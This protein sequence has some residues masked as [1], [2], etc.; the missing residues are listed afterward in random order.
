MSK[1][2]ERLLSEL[3]IHCIATPNPYSELSPNSYFVDGDSPTLI[4]TGLATRK[5]YEALASALSQLGRQISDIERIIL[6]HGHTDHRA[7][8]PRIGEESGAEVFFHSLEAGKAL[9]GWERDE[10]RR[11]SWTEIFRTMGVPEE[12]LPGLVIGPVTPLI[13]PDTVSTSFIDEGDEIAF[14]NFKLSVLHTP[15][16]SCGSICLYDKESGILFSGDT[17]LS[18]SHVTAL[19]EMGMIREDPNYNGLKLHMESLRRL[20][21]LDASCVLPGHG[22]VLSE[23][24]SIVDDLLERHSKRRRHI[25]RSLRNG[26]RSLYRICKS[27]FL[28]TSPDDLYLALSEVMGNIGILI[29]EGGVVKTRDGDIA[30]YEKA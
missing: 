12:E 27:T 10:D 28:F 17:I 18:G 30:Y 1:P 26:R 8:A 20:T 5:A 23:Y 3:G 9:K 21:G 13:D 14:D 15:G 24:T 4:D 6:T 2:T 22:E 16:H 11:Q 19:L 25:L 29:D 7:L